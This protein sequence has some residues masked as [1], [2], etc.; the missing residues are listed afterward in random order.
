[1]L[2]VFFHNMFFIRMATELCSRWC[3]QNVPLNISNPKADTSAQFGLV[4][5]TVSSPL[6]EP[7]RWECMKHKPWKNKSTGECP[8][9]WFIHT[10][11]QPS[12]TFFGVGFFFFT[13]WRSFPSSGTVPAIATQSI[14]SS[15]IPFFNCRTCRGVCEKSDLILFVLC[16]VVCVLWTA[17]VDLSRIQ[18]RNFCNF[19]GTILE[20]VADRHQVL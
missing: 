6:F 1:M 13:T 15:L 9:K 16:C 2:H 11:R 4:K 10:G 7:W 3:L 19:L 5:R 20:E 14:V 17:N 8:R 12:I 18:S